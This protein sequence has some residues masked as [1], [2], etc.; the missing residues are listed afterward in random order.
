MV[1]ITR[2]YYVKNTVR[3]AES[4]AESGPLFARLPRLQ[5]AA[6]FRSHGMGVGVS[7]CVHKEGVATEQ[8]HASNV[9]KQSTSS[10]HTHAYRL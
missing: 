8:A 4:V 1:G 9:C 6:L 2:R 7:Q 5:R 3:Q 10:R